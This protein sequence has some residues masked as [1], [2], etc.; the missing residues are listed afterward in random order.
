MPQSQVVV[1]PHHHHTA[2]SGR[3][4]ATF[5]SG[6]HG[7]IDRGGAGGLWRRERGRGGPGGGRTVWNMF[8]TW[9]CSSRIRSAVLRMGPEGTEAS[10]IAPNTSSM[11]R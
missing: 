9:Y 4:E 3:N 2:L 6:G 5:T 8:L 7:S 10:F 11:L 1:P